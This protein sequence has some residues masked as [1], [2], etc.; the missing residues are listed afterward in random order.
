[1][2]AAYRDPYALGVPA[3]ASGAI[4]PVN[5]PPTDNQITVR[6][7]EKV[8]PPDASFEAFYIPSKVGRYTVGYPAPSPN[9]DRV[10]MASN[11]G[12]Q[13]LNAA[14]AAG[15]LYVQ[16]DPS[17]IGYNPMKNMR[18]KDSKF[19]AC[20]T[21]MSPAAQATP[22]PSSSFIIPTPL[23]TAWHA[24]FRVLRED[25]LSLRIP[26][27]RRHV[28][29]GRCP[30]PQNLPL[31]G[32]DCQYRSAEHR[33]SGGRPGCT[34]HYDQFT[35]EDRAT[36][37]CTVVLT[38]AAHPDSASVVLPNEQRV[39]HP[40]REPGPHRHRIAYLRPLDSNQQAQG[41]PVNGTA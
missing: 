34:G 32:S 3:A 12:T 17:A 13:N 25:E 15:S 26:K 29:R 33:R 30:S 8:S 39:P 36:N 37:G 20:A 24:V 19:W 14:E 11:F 35:F 18:L 5:A 16:N 2:E 6:W 27:D 28:C 38:P 10:V 41:D 9:E 23:T 7:F 4:I 1:M 21:S 31:R 22:R 40:G